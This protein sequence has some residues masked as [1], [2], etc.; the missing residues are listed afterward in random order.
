MNQ[1]DAMYRIVDAI[2]EIR[3]IIKKR[4]EDRSEH[5]KLVSTIKG[6][7]NLYPPEPCP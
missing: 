6:G 7:Q 1:E 4:E 3:D 2:E 5:E